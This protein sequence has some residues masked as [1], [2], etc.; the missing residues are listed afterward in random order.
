VKRRE[1]RAPGPRAPCSGRAGRRASSLD[2]LGDGGARPWR[3]ASLP[4]PPG[5]PRHLSWF[6]RVFPSPCGWS[7]SLGHRSSLSPSLLGEPRGQVVSVPEPA[8]RA[9]GPARLYARACSTSPRAKS[10]LCPSLLG[11]T[12][13][14]VVSV[15]EPARRDPGPVFRIYAG[16]RTRDARIAPRPVLAS[17][18]GRRLG[19]R[20]GDPLLGRLLSAAGARAYPRPRRYS[21]GEGH[22]RSRGR[23]HGA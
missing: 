13:A 9:S 10:S 23:D 17:L 6:D 19:R 20:P 14:Q 4:S 8:R 16:P 18:R 21:C 12:R 1:R 7:A 22:P 3:T 11:E 2:V 15:P 5:S